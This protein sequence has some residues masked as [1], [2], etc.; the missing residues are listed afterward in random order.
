MS[1]QHVPFLPLTRVNDRYTQEA[2]ER[3]AQVLDRGWYL[4]GNELREFESAWADTCQVRNAVG[5][6]S[7][8]DA[9]Q[10]IL[11]G[12]RCLKLVEAGDE[13]LVPAQTFFATYLAVARAGLVP[14]PVD[15]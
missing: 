7:G 14:V 4:L 2:R 13:V 8:I 3:I 6:G 1:G 11:E 12:F 9:I 5:T 10:L 15:V